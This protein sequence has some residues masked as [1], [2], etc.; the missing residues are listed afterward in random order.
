MGQPN[1]TC[2][3]L[4]PHDAHTTDRGH[5]PWHH[6]PGVP[7]LAE[8]AAQQPL[9]RGDEHL[10]L[11]ERVNWDLIQRLAAKPHKH[12]NI[13]EGERYGLMV[14]GKFDTGCGGVGEVM[15]E[16]RTVQHLLDMAGVPEGWADTAHI[17][18]RVFLLISDLLAARERLARVASWHSLETGPGGLVGLYCIECGNA[19]PCET[20]R[21]AD[22]THEDL[23]ELPADV[24]DPAD[25]DAR[26][27]AQALRDFA[28]SMRV[29]AEDAPADEPAKWPYTAY[30]LAAMKAEE[31]AGPM[32]FLE[33]D[34]AEARVR[35]QAIADVVALL[36]DGPRCMDWCRDN[37]SLYSYGTNEVVHAALYVESVMGRAPAIGHEDDPTGTGGTP[38]HPEHPLD[39]CCTPL[40]CGHHING[41]GHGTHCT[42]PGC[43][44]R[45]WR[46]HVNCVHRAAPIN[47][48][49]Q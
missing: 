12:L 45:V 2:G 15:Q 27:R 28:E 4:T 19:H 35:A 18:A 44:C 11:S 16:A 14:D 8:P 21:M 48:E 31:R 37:R 32:A 23:A 29:L 13:V 33:D 17:D 47:E 25:R 36:S 41:H 46:D 42:E 5:A 3:D 43:D 34:T 38:E 9:S 40:G 6:C 24:V 7:N 20:R 1:R 39:L 49:D 10:A 26:V 30:A 22:G